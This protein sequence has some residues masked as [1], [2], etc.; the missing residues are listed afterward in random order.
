MKKEI[1]IAGLLGGAVIFVWLIISQ[2]ILPFRSG[3]L[4]NTVDNQKNLHETLKSEITEP[5]IY[6]CPYLPPDATA[7]F[8]DYLNEP[9]YQIIYKGETHST[10]AGI[11]GFP[12]L[13]IFIAPMI[14]AWMLSVSSEKIL[15]KYSRRVLFITALGLFL[16]VFGDLF[17]LNNTFATSEF[18]FFTAGNDI[19]TWALAGLVIA[20]KIKPVKV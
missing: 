10:V 15:A 1:F 2:A 16:A 9:I 17:Q 5:G 11:F 8:P 18:T 7:P 6:V 12:L 3:M 19:I 14:A 4:M 20:W 13:M